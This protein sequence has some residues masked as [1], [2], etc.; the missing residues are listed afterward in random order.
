VQKNALKFYSFFSNPKTIQ[1]NYRVIGAEL[2][3]KFEQNAKAYVGQ[4][5]GTASFIYNTYKDVPQVSRAI[6]QREQAKSE[7]QQPG[8]NYP[9]DLEGL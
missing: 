7:K 3:K 5:G 6:R 8:T 4:A 1:D 9:Q 2:E